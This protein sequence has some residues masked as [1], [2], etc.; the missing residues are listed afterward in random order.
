[1]DLPLLYHTL[2]EPFL[3]LFI[4]VSI[5]SQPLSIYPEL[6]VFLS[7]HLCVLHFLSLPASLP[8]T[9]L[10]CVAFFF[11]FCL[12]ILCSLHSFISALL[13]LMSVAMARSI[14]DGVFVLSTER[15]N[16]CGCHASFPPDCG[17]VWMC[18]IGVWCSRV[19]LFTIGHALI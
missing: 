14:Q 4:K 8:F 12:A 15:K 7:F 10:W 5:Q 18:V 17:R 16:E 2:P 13:P 1:M 9:I 19:C 3:P 11:F 6:F